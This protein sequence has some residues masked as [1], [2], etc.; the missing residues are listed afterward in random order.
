MHNLQPIDWTRSA[1][2]ILATLLSDVIGEDPTPVTSAM[3]RNGKLSPEHYAEF[4]LSFINAKT[5]AV[6][7][8]DMTR[9]LAEEIAD[10]QT[11]LATGG[12]VLHTDERQALLVQMAPALG[13]SEG[14]L[15]AM[16]RIGRPVTKRWQA[17]GFVA[18]P[19][20]SQIEF[21][22]ARNAAI[23]STE[24]MIN[25]ASDKLNAVREAR[26]AAIDDPAK[27]GAEI[28]AA[29]VEAFG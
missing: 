26:R 11:A 25:D 5:L 2:E 17:E 28:I 7:A 16:L 23:A 12:F 3:L 21:I 8:T 22:Q 15:T 6:D 14:L 13:W 24:Q 4:R 10:T 9:I 19:T 18:E 20:L 1:S 27:T 29:T